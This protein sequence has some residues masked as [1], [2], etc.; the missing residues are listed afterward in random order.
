MSDE[1]K[2]SDEHDQDQAELPG[3]S[4]GRVK[5]S[6]DGTRWTSREAGSQ[7]PDRLLERT[8]MRKGPDG[9]YVVTA[10]APKSGKKTEPK[11]VSRCGPFSCWQDVT[12]LLMNEVGAPT[13]DL[14]PELSD[15]QTEGVERVIREGLTQDL[16]EKARRWVHGVGA[17]HEADA[18]AGR[19][20]PAVWEH[21]P[22]LDEG[23]TAEGR[24]LQKLKEQVIDAARLLNIFRES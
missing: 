4:I 14:G 13:G 20:V 8:T 24:R 12:R 9:W 1:Q 11:A 6:S 18:L 21:H 3:G 16:F 19:K 2:G 15:D 7:P 17:Q 23:T 5:T 22:R 10:G